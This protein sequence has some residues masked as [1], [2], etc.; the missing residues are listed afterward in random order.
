MQRLKLGFQVAAVLSLSVLL[1]CIAID[2]EARR[3]IRNSFFTVYPSAVG[4]R[5]DELASNASHCGVC[6][7]DFDGGGPRN[8]YGLAVE[9]ARNSGQYATD[10]EAIQSIENN[11]SDSD[12]FK[13]LVEITDTIHFTNTPTFPGL[14]QNNVNNTLNVSIAE[15][16]GHV[17]PLGSTDTIPPQV[18]VLSPNG[19]EDYTAMNVHSVTWAATDESG[20]SHVDIYLSDDNGVSFKPVAKGKIDDGLFEWFV[21]NLPASQNIIKVMARDNAGN[22]GS[23]VS[24]AV[25]AITGTTGGKAPTTLRDM[26]LA[27]TQPFEGAAFDDPDAT[28]VTCHG[29]YD[30]A[31]EPYYQWR[32]SMM[33]QAARDPLF[34]ACLAVSEQDAPSV[35]DLCLRCHT[36]TGWQEGRSVDTSGGMLTATDRHGVH[37]DFCHRAVDPDFKHGISPLEDIAVLDSL[38]AIPLTYANGQFVS[39]PDPRRRG[40]YFDAVASHAFLESPFHRK[41]HICGTC[42]D[43]SNPVFVKGATHQEYSPNTFDAK[44][45]DGDLRNMFPIERTYS[46]WSK[47]EYAATGVYAPQFAG[48]KPDGIVSTC[49][50]CHMRDVSGRGCNQPGAPTR[51][52][53]PLHDLMG[54][55]YFI[56]DILPSFFPTEVDSLQM[57]AGKQRAVSMLQ[58]AATMD[59]SIGQEG[60]NPTVTVQV[61]NQTAHKLP[62]G[63]PEGRRIWLNVKA[64]DSGSNVIYESG[65]YD[66]ATGVLTHDDDLMIYEIKPGI[67]SRLS[68]IVGL[69]VGPS[70]HFVLNDSIFFDS[71]IPPR[72]FTNSN[73]E[74]IQSTPVAYSYA[75]GQY[76]DTTTYVLPVEASLVRATLYYQST[77]KEYVEFLRDE[78]ETNTAGQELYDA[79]VAQGRAAPVTM[80]TDTISVPLIDVPVDGAPKFAN[81]LFQNVPNPFNPV[82]TIQYSLRSDGRVTIR[83]FDVD[84]GLVRTLVDAF[85]PAGIHQAVWDGR[86]DSGLPV[87]SGVYLVSM[88]TSEYRESRKAVLLR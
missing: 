67:S 15:I 35:G 69:P 63:Y 75:D 65:A 11:D 88:E 14:S 58:K 40:P 64:Y 52:D 3:P 81:V 74:E 43:V 8:P 25:F 55:N 32:G 33:A 68:P 78:N 66:A 71:R 80:V 17:T 79:W 49:Q 20:I 45:P 23:D 12:G 27:G 5:L 18:T 70:F 28:C 21:P 1:L 77:S 87:S 29:N 37:C 24:D 34:F 7:F 2:S 39:D 10:E 73:F 46:E 31:V 26:E 48:N 54:G 51:D 76:W 82:S 38:E 60:S 44:H 9:V 19:G 42:H 36:P 16:G 72:G 84:G 41:S 6:H 47:S 30:T 62:S 85:K 61:T 57:A 86:N 4:S 13:N 59:L 56:P 53:L 22:Y 83:V 50:D